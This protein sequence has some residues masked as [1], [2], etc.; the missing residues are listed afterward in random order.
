MPRYEL[1]FTWATLEQRGNQGRL[2]GPVM[3]LA[4]ALHGNV[5]Y[6]ASTASTTLGAQ[7]LTAGPC[8]APIHDVRGFA[9]LTCLELTA[10]MIGASSIDHET[11]A[12]H[13]ETFAFGSVGGA[14]E[15]EYNLGRHFHVALRAGASALVAPIAVDASDGREL[16]RSSRYTAYATL[17]L[18]G[19]F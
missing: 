1:S 6:D 4:L 14:L 17:G 19:H 18:G 7:S 15:A 3:R 13:M 8:Y 2:L 12:K 11:K 10:G 5:T 16:F 9:L